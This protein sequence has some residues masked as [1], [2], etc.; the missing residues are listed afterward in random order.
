MIFTLEVDLAETRRTTKNYLFVTQMAVRFSAR[1]Y[2]YSPRLSASM[3][4]QA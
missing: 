4:L 1:Q 3:F 2:E